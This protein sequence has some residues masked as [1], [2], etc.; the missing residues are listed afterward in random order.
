MMSNC[1]HEMLGISNSTEGSESAV[2]KASSDL[3]SY[4]EYSRDDLK[5]HSFSYVVHHG[6]QSNNI[7]AFFCIY[8][9]Y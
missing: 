2:R 9:L 1:A 6:K 8:P 5:S 4:V 3:E 7:R